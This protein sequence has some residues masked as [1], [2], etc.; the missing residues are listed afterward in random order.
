MGE[1]VKF[2]LVPHGS[3]G[4]DQEFDL[5]PHVSASPAAHSIVDNLSSSLEDSNELSLNYDRCNKIVPWFDLASSPIP[6]AAVPALRQRFS[7]SPVAGVAASAEAVP[8]PLTIS[9]SP[10]QFAISFFSFPQQS[11]ALTAV[12]AVQTHVVFSS[13]HPPTYS[14]CPFAPS[15]LFLSLAAV[16]T[17]VPLS[18]QHLGLS[19]HVHYWK[20]VAQSQRDFETVS[21]LVQLD[22]GT[23]H[24]DIGQTCYFG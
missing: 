16:E 14:Q 24:P 4:H 20:E 12:S 5:E 6:K 19:V 3:V 22:L 10:L 1:L 23:T 15:L 2:D 8:I 13:S 9:F 21:E 17:R 18:L 7:D 11:A